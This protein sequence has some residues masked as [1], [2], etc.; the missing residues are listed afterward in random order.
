MASSVYLQR[1]HTSDVPPSIKITPLENLFRFMKNGGID[2]PEYLF[3]RSWFIHSPKLQEKVF[4]LIMQNRGHLL[5]VMAG[6]FEEH[7][8]SLLV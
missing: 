8:D 3:E 4:R 1:I 7:I 5:K 6:D 2:F